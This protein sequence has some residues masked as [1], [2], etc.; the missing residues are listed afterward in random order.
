MQTILERS[1]GELL[2]AFLE[3]GFS[4][5]IVRLTTAPVDISWNGYTWEGIRG[6]LEIGAIAESPGDVRSQAVPLTLS[7][8]EQSILALLLQQ[9]YLGRPLRIWTGHIN[10]GANALRRS[11]ALNLSPWSTSQATITT[12][13]GRADDGKRTADKLVEA[14]TNNV[15]SV[16]QSWTIVAGRT[17]Y[18]ACRVRS[19]ERSR[20]RLSLAATPSG[21]AVSIRFNLDAGTIAGVN[22][23]SGTLLSSEITR[24]AGGGYLIE[25]FATLGGSDTAVISS[26]S[27]ED[28]SG[29][30][31]YSGD[32][33]SGLL[34][35]DMHAL[36][37]SIKLPYV[38]T[39]DVA[40][41][42]GK[43]A[44]SPYW[45]FSGYMN[46]GVEI[47]ETVEEESASCEIRLR[48]VSRSAMFSNRR[49]IKTNVQSH[50][51]YFPGDRFFQFVPQLANR[52]INWGTQRVKVNPGPSYNLPSSAGG[53]APGAIG[54]RP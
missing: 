26:V 19:L 22:A 44:D 50:Q 13:A 47:E 20:G 34:V 16:A 24:L 28:G 27:L 5:G 30:N 12:N 10:M 43:V 29:N 17:V 11:R 1:G 37:L 4:G 39:A 8:V 7:G 49:G 42:D 46:G 31:S 3:L 52:T 53:S 21:N 40:R 54:R 15:H 48:A 2:V 38:E 14:A 18:F 35:W 32:G 36:P 51:Q 9:Q 25:G 41:A 23:G 33:S 6:H 45:C